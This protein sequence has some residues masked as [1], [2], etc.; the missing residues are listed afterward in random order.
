MGR[1]SLGQAPQWVRDRLGLRD[2]SKLGTS[3]AGHVF[4]HRWWILDEVSDEA[5]LAIL[6][7]M[8]EA[9][10]ASGMSQNGM[11][12]CKFRGNGCT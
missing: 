9:S 10:A 3:H 5:V 8:H 4:F 11:V 1:R 6:V 2:V 12:F 7:D